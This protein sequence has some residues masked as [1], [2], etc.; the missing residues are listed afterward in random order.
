MNRQRRIYLAKSC[1][2]L[3]L[4][5]VLIYAHAAGPDP[6]KSGVPGESTCNEIGCH[7]GTGLNAGPGSVK[8]TA[9]SSTYVPGVKQRIQVTVSDPNQRRYGFQFTARLGS[10][11][12]TRAGLVSSIDATTLVLCTAANL[13]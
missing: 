8:I 2:F 9:E 10:N 13:Q 11:A 5:P 7:V 6:G 4:I 12:K 1:V 3:A